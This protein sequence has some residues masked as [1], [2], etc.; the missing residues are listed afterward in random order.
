M[1]I[2]SAENSPGTVHTQLDI[3]AILRSQKIVDEWRTTSANSYDMISKLYGELFPLW[4]GKSLF[5]VLR[6]TEAVI[7]GGATT[8]I[9]PGDL[10]RVIGNYLDDLD[11]HLANLSST[12]EGHVNEAIHTA[13]WA[14]YVFEKI[15]PFY[16]GNGR[17]GRMIVKRVLRGAGFRDI[18]FNDPRWYGENHSDHIE[19]LD[20]TSKTGDLSHVELYLLK[21]V[22]NSYLTNHGSE[23]VRNEIDSVIEKKH[24]SIANSS[25]R[26]GKEHI[27]DGFATV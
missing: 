11:N 9:H 4:R 24:Q 20:R 7:S 5:Q 14:Y 21:Q 18:I 26:Q 16:D 19:A 15:H 13:A 1:G 17:I 2:A 6:Q 3:A 10:P 27:W 12:P 23:I 8:T 22:R 25:G